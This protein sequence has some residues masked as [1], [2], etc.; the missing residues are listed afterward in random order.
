MR[1]SKFSDPSQPNYNDIFEPEE[2][3]NNDFLKKSTKNMGLSGF[4]NF[5][6]MRDT[7]LLFNSRYNINTSIVD[8]G[9]KLFGTE[10]KQTGRARIKMTESFDR[11]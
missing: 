2:R 6:D 3:I 4:M 7:K 1:R 8:S 10:E 11:I 5:S 9:S